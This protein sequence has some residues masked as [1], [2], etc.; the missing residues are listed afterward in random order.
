MV[1]YSF[2]HKMISKTTKISRK[3]DWLF[4]FLNFFKDHDI[5]KPVRKKKWVGQGVKFSLAC[6]LKRQG[7]GAKWCSHLKLFIISRIRIFKNTL[8]SHQS[9]VDGGYF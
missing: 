2:F 5:G 8:K 6:R 1:S 4:Q 9:E 7:L 3:R